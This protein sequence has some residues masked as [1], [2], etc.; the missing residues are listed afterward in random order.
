L[1]CTRAHRTGF[2]GAVVSLTISIMA[3]Q[4]KGLSNAQKK[5]WAK[6]LYTK[7]DL[8]QKEISAKIGISE[9]SVCKWVKDGNWD[10]MR[11]NLLT[12]KSEILHDL[13]D[14]LDAMK[15]EAK[16]L[17]TDDDP[18]TKPDSDGIYKLTLAIKKLETETGLGE[19]I[20]IAEKFISFIKNEDFDLAQTITHW[21]D[22][23]I[24][25]KLKGA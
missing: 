17:A 12:T 13:Y 3:K 1:L 21:F 25:H 11:K 14:T 16:K 4:D 22:L 23:F 8:S 5:E 18:T 20:D 19:I 6:Q 24:E 7:G 10:T 15:K 2:A 9:Q